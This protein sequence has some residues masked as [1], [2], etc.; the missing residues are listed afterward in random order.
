MIPRPKLPAFLKRSSQERGQD[1]KARLALDVKALGSE[2]EVGWDPD[3]ELWWVMDRGFGPHA[4]LFLVPLDYPYSPPIILAPK[5]A[6]C[7][8]ALG[9]CGLPESPMAGWEPLPLIAESW[10][11]GDDLRRASLMVRLLLFGR[12]SSH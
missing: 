1:L 5:K 2:A 11:P 10:Q 9:C 12:A 6:G 7:C 8:D 3:R 4:L